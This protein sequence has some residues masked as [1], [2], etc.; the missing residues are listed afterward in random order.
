MT[1]SLRSSGRHLERDGEEDQVTE[2]KD[3]WVTYGPTG[4]HRMLR[5]P[6]RI[7]TGDMYSLR[8]T[9]LEILTGDVTNIF[10]VTTLSVVTVPIMSLGV[11]LLL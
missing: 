2:G 3:R 10:T 5:N 9:K 11:P 1:R 7:I 4:V 8:R 6:L